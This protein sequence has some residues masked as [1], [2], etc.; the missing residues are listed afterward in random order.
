MR[1]FKEVLRLKFEARLSH[2]RI[3]AATGVSKGAVGKYV[4]R[5][6]QQGLSC[7]LPEEVDDAAL[8][9]LLF[10]QLVKLEQYTHAD[11][12]NVHQEFKRKGVTP[13]LLWEEYRAAHG[14]RAYQYSQFCWHYQRFRESLAR[15]MRQSHRAGEKRFI[16]YSGDTVPVLNV[17]TGRS[18]ARRSLS[19]RW[20][21]ASTPTRRRPGRSNFPTGLPRTSGCSSTWGAFQRS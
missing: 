14:E 9:R 10:P 15:S 12:A 3:A 7:P 18:C 11:Y 20:A 16:D 13:Q 2:E 4:Q 8:E 17:V 1:K 5:A 21:R 19:P 6:I